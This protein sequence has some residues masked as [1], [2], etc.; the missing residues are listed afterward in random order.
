MTGKSLRG[1]SERSL[2]SIIL[3]ELFKVAKRLFKVAKK[4]ITQEKEVMI[5]EILSRQELKMPGLITS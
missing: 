3:L 4:V 1:G 5:E 2:L